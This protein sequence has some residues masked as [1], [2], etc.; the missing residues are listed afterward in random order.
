[1]RVLAVTVMVLVAVP[2]TA[3][4]MT[5]N[6]GDLPYFTATGAGMHIWEKKGYVDFWVADVL[7][8]EGKKVGTEDK[9]CVPTLGQQIYIYSMNCELGRLVV[10]QDEDSGAYV[11]TPNTARLANNLHI[12]VD[13]DNI[14]VTFLTQQLDLTMNGYQSG[15]VLPKVSWQNSGDKTYTVPMDFTTTISTPGNTFGFSMDPSGLITV[16]SQPG[17]GA[18]LVGGQNQMYF[19]GL[20]SFVV[21]GSIPGLQF[22]GNSGDMGGG[23]SLK[24]GETFTV[25]PGTYKLFNWDTARGD[26]SGWWVNGVNTDQV[27]IP[28]VITD[29]W[30]LSISWVNPANGDVYGM[31]VGSVPEPATMSLLA[32]GG[33]ALLRRRR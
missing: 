15:W 11:V 29:D 19:D 31:T 8:N 21:E 25:L 13:G 17:T 3:Q 32:L 24:D 28:S 10:T 1:M 33:L 20:V 2:A 6:G 30:G 5:F 7:D 16:D 26:Q 12:E 23:D 18:L 27:T 9:L 22:T 4:V 14:S